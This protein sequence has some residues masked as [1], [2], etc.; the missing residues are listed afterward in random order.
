MSTCLVIAGPLYSLLA[1]P[2][3]P[4]RRELLRTSKGVCFHV[5]CSK[6]STLWRFSRHYRRPVRITICGCI[7]YSLHLVCMVENRSIRNIGRCNSLQRN[8]TAMRSA[9]TQLVSSY[10]CRVV[11]GEFP[12]KSFR[13]QLFAFCGSPC[14][15]GRALILFETAMQ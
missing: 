2:N 11:S 15:A 6:R 13:S 4:I 8:I 5:Q 12:P 14:S 10:K 7:G 3:R 1:R 9:C